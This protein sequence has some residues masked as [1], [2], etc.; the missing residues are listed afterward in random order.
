MSDALPSDPLVSVVTPSFNQGKYIRDTLDSVQRQTYRK[1]EHIVV[2]GGSTDETVA[3]LKEYPSVSWISEPDRG[4]ADALNKALRMAKG[5]IIAWINSDDFYE[6][7]A[8]ELAVKALRDAPIAMGRCLV[9]E[10]GKGPLYTVP[11]YGRT[12]FD[13]LKYWIAYS[14]PTQPSIF[15]RRSLLDSLIRNETEY[16]D[17]QLHYCMDYDLWIRIAVSYPLTTRIDAVTSHYRFTDTNKTSPNRPILSYAGA[18]MAAVFHRAEGMTGA[19]RQISFVIYAD[20]PSDSLSHTVHSLLTNAKADFEIIIATAKVSGAMRRFIEEINAAQEAAKNYRFVFPIASTRPSELGR[21]SE[22]IDRCAGRII[23]VLP[24]GAIAAT[25][26]CEQLIAA[27]QNDRLGIVLPFAGHH[28]FVKS[29]TE[30]NVEHPEHA[31]FSFNTFLFSDCPHFAFAI[32]RVS[33]LEGPGLRD[34]SHPLRELKRTVATRIR[35]GWHARMKTAALI[36]FPEHAAQPATPIFAQLTGAE[37]IT[38][39][40]EIADSDPFWGVRNGYGLC[41]RF[42]DELVSKTRELVSQSG[43]NWQRGLVS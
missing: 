8:L 39:A 11:N 36:T 9:F 43:P 14:I 28:A 18:E 13:L 37:V 23:T 41:Y 17:P 25:D 35:Q 12:W 5:D 42:P 22:A 34:D 21:I 38:E 19:S 4:Q 30:V 2:D 40:N 33:W 24:A 20:E 27:F 29:L 26:L 3:I 7:N 6:P 10:D 32:R 31:D 15:F 1:F 16:V